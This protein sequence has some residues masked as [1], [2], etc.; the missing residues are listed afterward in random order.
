M[1][2]LAL[3]LDNFAPWLMTPLLMLGGAYLCFEGAEKVHEALFPHAEHPKEG[4]AAAGDPAKAE[5]A[6][7]SGA[8]RTDFILSAEIM[9]VTLS[10]VA[11][12]SVGLQAGVLAVV[13]AL[14][15]VVVYGAVALIVK[16]DDAGLYL[17]A[18]GRTGFGRALGRGMVAGVPWLLQFLTVAGTAA[19]LWVGGGII[20]HSL[21]GYGWTGIEHAV[22][23][24][25]VAAAAMAGALSGVVGWAVEAAGCH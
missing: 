25:S 13:G 17:A 7:V 14:I 20:V 12:Q 8:I 2:P 24:V 15:T 4:A 18:H 9:A 11:D 6:R 21:A 10:T 3:L 23:E 22:H 16:A 5:A 19:M 1:L